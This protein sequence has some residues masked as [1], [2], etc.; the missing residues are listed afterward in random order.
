MAGKRPPKSFATS[1][2]DLSTIQPG[3]KL[4]WHL[5]LARYPDPLGFGK[6]PSR[7]SDPRVAMPDEER[8]GVFYLGT[9]IQVC[10]LETVLRD[11]RTARMGYLPIEQ[12]ELQVWNTVAVDF[13]EPALLVDLTGDGAV[14]MGLPTDAVRTARHHWGQIWSLAIWSHDS[15]PDG[16]M[17]PSRLNGETN[18]AL[19]DRAMPKIRSA[20]VV[21]LMHQY[22]AMADIVRRFDL[23]IV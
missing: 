12:S 17:F 10:F 4:W 16:I 22:G 11:R 18:I 15:Q 13:G 1:R 9:S 20:G 14:R 23:A 2:L 6:T 8:F 21:P 7:F 19:F 5:T 3:S